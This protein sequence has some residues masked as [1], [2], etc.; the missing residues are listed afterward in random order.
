M[1]QNGTKQFVVGT[2]DQGGLLNL[3]NQHGQTVLIAGTADEGL[4]GAVS[5]KNGDGRQ[6]LHMGYDSRGDGL[7]TAWSADGR[8]SKTVTPKR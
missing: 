7:V 1:N 8:S 5:V 6:V 2:R 4:G 3:M